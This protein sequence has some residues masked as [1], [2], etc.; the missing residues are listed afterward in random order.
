VQQPSHRFQ[1]DG[2]GKK[3]KT[4]ND[5]HT[6]KYLRSNSPAHNDIEPIKYKRHD[7]DIEQVDQR[8]SDKTD[9]EKFHR[10]NIGILMQLS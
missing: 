5:H 7:S 10:M 2:L 9:F 3:R 1:V 6:D 8:D 4:D